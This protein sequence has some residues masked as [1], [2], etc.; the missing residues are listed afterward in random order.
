MLRSAHF[1]VSGLTALFKWGIESETLMIDSDE[2]S[3][4]WDKKKRK[5]LI[6][7]VRIDMCFKSGV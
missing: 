3:N 6:L 5:K 4:R 2:H 1:K 7:R